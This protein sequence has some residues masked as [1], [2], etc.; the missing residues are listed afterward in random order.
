MKELNLHL[1]PT[2][3]DSVSK[4]EDP[5]QELIEFR[6]NF[7]RDSSAFFAKNEAEILTKWME[8]R[9]DTLWSSSSK[10][11]S[12]S[13]ISPEPVSMSTK[14]SIVIPSFQQEITREILDYASAPYKIFNLDESLPKNVHFAE[15][16]KNINYLY[17]PLKR[18]VNRNDRTSIIRLSGMS[19]ELDNKEIQYTTKV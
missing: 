15:Q 11:T 7:D 8:N 5:S 9:F 3:K 17:M 13:M 10:K 19:N 12:S 16:D 6:D 2:N 18:L 14:R 1:T 4:G